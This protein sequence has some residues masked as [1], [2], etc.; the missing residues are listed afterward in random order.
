MSKNVLDNQDVVNPTLKFG[1]LVLL[2]MQG[3]A[4]GLMLRYSQGILKESYSSYGN[5]RFELYFIQYNILFLLYRGYHDVGTH[6]A[7]GIGL[8]IC[9]RQLR[10][11]CCTYTI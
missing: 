11:R 3:A 10:N 1:I 2:G 8:F 4:H 7:L 9:R 6:Q 5:S